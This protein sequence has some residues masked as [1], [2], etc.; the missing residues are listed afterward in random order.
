MKI[1]ILLPTKK[2][3]SDSLLISGLEYLSK[4]SLSYSCS[5]KFIQLPKKFE[6]KNAHVKKQQEALVFSELSKNYYTVAMEENAKHF[7]SEGFYNFLQKTSLVQSKVCF[8][9][10]GAFGL[11]KDFSQSCNA[12][13]S[14]SSLTL[15]HRLAFLVL[16]E[17][18]FRASQ[19]NIGTSYHK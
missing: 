8:I 6:E 3:N 16:C 11:D 4:I 12:R 17:Q 13:M 9:I 1:L 15:P 10:G 19:I 18:L 7:S 14:L 5:H 2:T